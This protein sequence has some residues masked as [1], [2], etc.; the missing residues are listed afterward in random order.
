M[1]CLPAAWEVGSKPA[2][3]ARAL[4]EFGVRD[5]YTLRWYRCL[6]MDTLIGVAMVTADHEMR[7][8]R[9]GLGC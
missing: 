4:S 9:V 3:V 7:L 8:L 1:S 2:R 5:I 6:V